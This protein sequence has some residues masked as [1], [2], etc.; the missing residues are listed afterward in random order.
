MLYNNYNNNLYLLA[1]RFYVK[2]KVGYIL[3]TSHVPNLPFNDVNLTLTGN[4]PKV[5]QSQYK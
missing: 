4:V 5:E 3:T 1:N 2:F